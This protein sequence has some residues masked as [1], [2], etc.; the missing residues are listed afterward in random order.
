M[1]SA[2]DV[3]AV[4]TPV[5]DR[6]PFICAAGMN[7][8]TVICRSSEAV[9]KLLL[10]WRRAGDKEF[11]HVVELSKPGG[12]DHVFKVPAALPE[13]NDIEMVIIREE[14]QKILEAVSGK[15]APAEPY[16]FN[17]GET[18]VSVGWKSPDACSAA[19]EYRLSGSTESKIAVPLTTGNLY[20]GKSHTIHLNDLQS[21]CRYDYRILKIDPVS[22]RKT[23]VGKWYTFSTLKN[24]K[25][26]C[27]MVFFSDIHADTETF[28]AFISHLK[29]EKADF[30]VLAGDLCWDG[31]YEAEGKPFFEDFLDQ[32]VRA[33]AASV[34]TVFMR[35][36]HEWTGKF[37]FQ[38]AEFFP[39]ANSRTYGAFRAG[40]CCF[41]V[42]DTGPVGNFS[43]GTPA[44]DYI[45]EQRAWLENVI[46]PSEMFRNSKFR[47]VLAHM[48]TH[49]IPNAPLLEKS[50]SGLF[51]RGGIQLM[52]V[53]HVHRYMRINRNDDG[54]YGTDYY[55]IW[56]EENPPRSALDKNY[57]LVIN[58]GGPDE[59]GR[60]AT[61]LEMKCSTDFLHLRVIGKNGS[62][63]D[64]FRIFPD[65]KV[66]NIFPA[67]RFPFRG[68]YKK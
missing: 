22:S 25:Q 47:I 9:D 5:I 16:L 67:R 12:R 48:P 57:T 51:N 50:F 44:G 13:E 29:P 1:I 45:A 33:F 43:P 11:A 37:S 42:L 60:F 8:F 59:N 56:N 53:G 61:A 7:Y 62:N 38:W 54:C 10:R 66:E 19:V 39:S 41:I 36:N 68:K 49:G 17:P 23:P 55:T 4:K 30:A 32:S 46:M 2:S 18:S 15:S 3:P 27:R 14:D 20:V 26:G 58:G 24:G 63:I 40:D 34:P 21:G 65:G 31:V 28:Q 35:G 64:E 6:G 52:I